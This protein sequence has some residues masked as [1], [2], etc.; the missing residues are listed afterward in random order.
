MSSLKEIS[1]ISASPHFQLHAH[2]F[3]DPAPT[4]SLVRT[5]LALAL[6][7]I[8]ANPTIAAD[9]IILRNTKVIAD[10]KVVA[11]DP[12][13]IVFDGVPTLRVTWDEVEAGRV[14]S[15]QERF[16]D[17]LRELGE[18]LYRIRQRT[19]TGDDR[20][21]LPIAESVLPTFRDRRSETAFLVFVGLARARKALG[22]SEGV[23]EPF[24]LAVDCQRLA[25]GGP[26]PLPGDRSFDI[27]R[28]THLSPL[29]VPTWHDREA[30]LEALPGAIKALEDSTKP[31]PPGHLA[32]VAALAIAAGDDAEAGRLLDEA[33]A[34]GPTGAV[35]DLIAVVE[36]RRILERPDG[37]AEAA[38]SLA[39]IVADRRSAER[40]LARYWLGVALLRSESVEYRERGVVALLTLPAL[41]VNDNPELAAEGLDAAR[42]GLEAMGD[43]SAGILG[44]ELLYRFPAS[45]AS[46]RLTAELQ[47]SPPKP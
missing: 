5:L 21:I 24:L 12:D 39:E 23:L 40:P 42:R 43:P 44:S 45:S 16:D 32:Y 10:R 30:A 15:G 6:L 26:L 14:D 22:Q 29:I 7:A 4:R 18:P 1:A 38:E 3:A 9:R 20:D 37:G 34:D 41:H 36:A 19:V 47:S 13:G 33:R 8:V 17:L 11:F 25:K 31:R 2:L 28:S 35:A 46:A 27:N